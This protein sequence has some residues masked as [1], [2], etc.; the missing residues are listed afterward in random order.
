ML[1][2]KIL[3]FDV[4]KTDERTGLPSTALPYSSISIF[5]SC[6]VSFISG[7]YKIGVVVSQFILSVAL[8]RKHKG[9]TFIFSIYRPINRKTFLSWPFW[10]WSMLGLNYKGVSCKSIFRVSHGANAVAEV[11]RTFNRRRRSK[12]F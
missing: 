6:S 2:N 10:I 5:L 1:R 8:C 9:K 4:H 7:F 12:I 3:S 11:F